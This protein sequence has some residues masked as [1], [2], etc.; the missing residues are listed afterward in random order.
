MSV[1]D[2]KP[3]TDCHFHSL[4]FCNKGPSCEFR[5]VHANQIAPICNEWLIEK[6]ANI[7][8]PSRH[9]T[10]P[11]QPDGARI[12]CLYGVRCARA[13]QCL[14]YHPSQTKAI[15][16]LGEK[17][18]ITLSAPTTEVGVRR[19]TTPKSTTAPTPTT[20]ATT[21]SSTTITRT[22]SNEGS[23]ADETAAPAGSS[24][25]LKPRIT[26]ASIPVAQSQST[27]PV[28][29]VKSLAEIQ[30][31]ISTNGNSVSK[32]AGRTVTPVQPDTKTQTPVARPLDPIGRDLTRARIDETTQVGG[33]KRKRVLPS[34]TTTAAQSISP[35]A[36]TAT[37]TATTTNNTRLRS[38]SSTVTQTTPT[39]STSAPNF[40]VK[41]LSELQTNA[42]P[43]QSTKQQQQQQQQNPPS[44]RQRTDSNPIS[45]TSTTATTIP[46]TTTSTTSTT[47]TATNAT[48]SVQQAKQQQEDE[49]QQADLQFELEGEEEEGDEYYGDELEGEEEEDLSALL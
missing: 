26:E 38:I 2:L 22:V 49:Q 6:C 35:T 25:L 17:R 10:I 8:C 7:D 47:T 1:V 40:G 39:S 20:E 28:S 27:Q 4:G 29:F 11:R 18:N 16:P 37:N 23:V 19:T 3:V 46:A 45:T 41:S 5:H 12:P 44:K 21:P 24:A 33:T 30:K 34:A 36:K 15:P 32:P 9:P 42:S 48:P 14:Y 13:D 31:E 43:A